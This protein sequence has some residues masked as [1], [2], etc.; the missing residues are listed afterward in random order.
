[1]KIAATMKSD[2]Q[3]FTPYNGTGG[4]VERPA[5]IERAVRE[6]QDGT[7]SKRQS[8]IVEQLDLAGAQGATWKTLGQ[9]LNLHHGQVSGALSN[10]HKAGEVFMLRAKQQRCHAYVLRRYR[11]AYTD[12]QVFDTPATTR[13]GERTALLN[14]LYATCQSANEVGWSAGMQHAVT[15]IVDMIAQHDRTT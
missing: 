6:A 12:E 7:L 11:W 15:T 14:E 3:L 4:Y 1:M 9:L 10:L 5:S 13:A 8:D 2:M